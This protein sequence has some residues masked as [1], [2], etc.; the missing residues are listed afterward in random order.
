MKKLYIRN[1]YTHERSR[2]FVTSFRIILKLVKSFKICEKSEKYLGDSGRSR[3]FVNF[4]WNYSKAWEKLQNSWEWNLIWSKLSHTK[5][6]YIPIFKK[7]EKIS[8]EILGNDLLH[9][10]KFLQNLKNC[11]WQIKSW[12]KTSFS[13][14]WKW[15]K[16][17]LRR[18]KA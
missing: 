12:E 15:Q 1:W 14:R 17:H 5:Y 9:G 8:D 11:C 18:Q 2:T 16:F 3:T 6:V 10:S 7:A 4:I 13:P